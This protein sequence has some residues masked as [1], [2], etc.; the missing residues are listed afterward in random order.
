MQ[1]GTRAIDEGARPWEIHHK[2]FSNTQNVRT[3]IYYQS[4][5]TKEATPC[6]DTTTML[7]DSLGETPGSNKRSTKKEKHGD[8]SWK[9]DDATAQRTTSSVVDLGNNNKN[10]KNK[11]TASKEEIAIGLNQSITNVSDVMATH[12]HSRVFRWTS[13]MLLVAF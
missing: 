2:T 8:G 7:N 3:M 13:F 4:S 10:N 12:S 6:K 9:H 5:R 11:Q 1:R